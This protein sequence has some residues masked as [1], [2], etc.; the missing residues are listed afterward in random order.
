MT[1]ERISK[2][3]EQDR[4]LKAK[5]R[6]IDKIYRQTKEKYNLIIII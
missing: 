3:R 1:I 4:I 6:Q 2:N 5:E